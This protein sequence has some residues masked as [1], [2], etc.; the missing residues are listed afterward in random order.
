MDV[1][2]GN[3]EIPETATNAFQSHRQFVKDNQIRVFILPGFDIARKATSGR[4]P[5]AHAGILPGRLLPSLLVLADNQISEDQFREIV[6]KQ[7]DKKFGRFGE[8][9][10]ESNMEVMTQGF[11]LTQEIVY[12]GWTTPIPPACVFAS[13][14]SDGSR[15]RSDRAVP[16]LVDSCIPKDSR[17]APK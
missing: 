2:Y 10:V 6:R 7:Y 4:T 16:N 1:W 5:V 8:A 11:N 9:V 15:N 17:N 13:C 14:S 3:R 12:G